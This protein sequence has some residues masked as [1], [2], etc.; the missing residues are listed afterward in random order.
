MDSYTVGK[1]LCGVD[2]NESNRTLDVVSIL[3]AVN[4]CIIHYIYGY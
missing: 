3:D 2:L 4:V 1:E